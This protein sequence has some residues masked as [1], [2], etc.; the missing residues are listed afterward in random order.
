[1]RIGING[2]GRMALRAALGGVHRPD[3]DPRR[4]NR[5]DI[6]HVNETP[7]PTSHA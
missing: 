1:M 6:V 5:L 4:G 7:S 2:M 3:D